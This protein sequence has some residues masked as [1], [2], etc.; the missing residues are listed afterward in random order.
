MKKILILT[1]CLFG[2]TKSQENNKQNLQF[3]NSSSFLV[4]TLLQRKFVLTTT[5]ISAV[6]KYHIQVKSWDKP[7]LWSMNI[8]SNGKSILTYSSL[9]TSIDSFFH[10]EGY[11]YN[12]SNY[13]ECKKKW[14]LDRIINF[15]IDT[16]KVKD[17]RRGN[18]QLE[19]NEVSEQYFKDYAI[20]DGNLK[21]L[22]KN[23]W[24][25]YSKKDK[26]SF[27]FYFAPE[28]RNI[29]SLAYFPKGLVFVPIYSE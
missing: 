15:S 19:S 7:V 23:Y 3:A 18:L 9:D 26:I 16:I 27:T 28:G 1:I 10:D 29:P 11:M 14:Y 13:I 22:Y 4:D 21:T 6:A 20:K 24:S 17:E 2:C 12:C 8:S 25:E 5:G